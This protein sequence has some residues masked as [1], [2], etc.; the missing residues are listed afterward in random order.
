MKPIHS[1]KSLPNPLSS[2]LYPSTHWGSPIATLLHVAQNEQ[3]EGD[4][5]K[6]RFRLAEPQEGDRKL[7]LYMAPRMAARALVQRRPATNPAGQG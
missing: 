5:G 3:F 4:A 1:E 2:K 6:P 7:P